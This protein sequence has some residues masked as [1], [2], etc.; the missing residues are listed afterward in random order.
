MV[1][2]KC[3]YGCLFCR[4]GAEANV[5]EHINQAIDGIDAI[6]PMRLRRKNISGKIFEDQVQ[7]PPAYIFFRTEQ[8]E[9]FSKLSQ[10]TNVIKLLKYNHF[11]WELVGS[12]REFEEFLFDNEPIQLPHTEFIDGRLHFGG[13]PIWT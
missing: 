2:Q 11:R 5:A 12:D 8:T 13:G 1:D 6:A 10:I 7:L 4:T 3:R 9:P